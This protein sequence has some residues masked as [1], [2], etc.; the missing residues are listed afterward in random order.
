MKTI[1]FFVTFIFFLISFNLVASEIEFQKCDWNATLENCEPKKIK[2]S[3]NNLLLLDKDKKL[4]G[5]SGGDHDN[6][7]Y[8]CF[9]LP[10]INLKQGKF[11]RS[12]GLLSYVHGMSDVCDAIIDFKNV[13]KIR[14]CAFNHR[15]GDQDYIE[16]ANGISYSKSGKKMIEDRKNCIKEK[17]FEWLLPIDPINFEDLRKTLASNFL[18]NFD[19]YDVNESKQILYCRDKLSGFIFAK[20]LVKHGRCESG[21]M[22]VTKLQYCAFWRGTNT[23]SDNTKNI[24]G[25]SNNQIVKNEQKEEEKRIAEEKRKVKEAE[26]N[27]LKPISKP[28]F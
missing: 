25:V 9:P 19:L 14:W 22:G 23:L 1:I 5:R 28:E 21:T 20:N 17:N 8:R 27:T 7:Y 6:F 13:D 24:C 16:S 26:D 10:F 2:I 15:L 12:Y 3:H 18:K 4:M 11:G